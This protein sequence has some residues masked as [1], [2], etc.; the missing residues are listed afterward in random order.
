MNCIE[1]DELLKMNVLQ[2]NA[3]YYVGTFCKCCGPHSRD[4][5]YFA[6]RKEAEQVLTDRQLD[7]ATP[8][9]FSV[10]PKDDLP[11]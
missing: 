3:G 1:C 7:E 5:E 9:D 6:T 4:S 11:W 8:V 2:S 10:D